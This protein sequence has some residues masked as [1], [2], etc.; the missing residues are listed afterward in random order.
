MEPDYPVPHSSWNNEGSSTVVLIHGACTSRVWWDLTIPHLPSSYHI[1][2]P[3][4]PGHGE[5]SQKAYSVQSSSD[6]IAQLITDK[7]INSKAHIIAHSLGADVAIHFA[8]AYPDL[9]DS[10]FVSGFGSIPQGSLT[11][12]VP[13]AVWTIQR[14]E[15]LIP[16]PV[17]RWAMDGTD[18]PATSLSSLD[19]CRQVMAPRA[20]WP[21]PWPARTL[22]VVAGK[23]GLIP[24]ADNPK[25]A[26]RLLETGQRGN[27]ETVAYV[28]PKMRH[29]W[30]R[31][32]PRLFADTAVAWIERKNLPGGFEKLD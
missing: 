3:D 11:P 27:S 24:S 18:L 10:I 29:P 28:H 23:G 20:E 12:V 1:L 8:C 30:N 13:Y 4:L 15:N 26:L 2:A 6:S 9:I 19:L 22:I 25:V 21:E 17:I 31:Q 5:A 7:A 14:I 16:R 32:D